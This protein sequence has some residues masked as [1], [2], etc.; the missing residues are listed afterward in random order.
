MS[1]LAG[2]PGA[3]IDIRSDSSSP[4]QS[5]HVR[6][7][8]RNRKPSIPHN[9]EIGFGILLPTIVE[10][11]MANSLPVSN[12][13]NLKEEL[14]IQRE[15]QATQDIHQYAMFQQDLSDR[16][17]DEL[18]RQNLAVVDKPTIPSRHSLSSTYFPKSSAHHPE[19]PPDRLQSPVLIPQRRPTDES[20]GWVRAYAPSLEGCGIDQGTFLHFLDEFN[21]ACKASHELLLILD[22]YAN[23]AS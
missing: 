2:V 17:N 21:E 22:N 1:K 3:G 20:R 7:S 4:C 16:L 12:N 15:A 9:Q 18:A 11:Q 13:T 10:T 8:N 19:G 14:R 23:T 5:P 6:R